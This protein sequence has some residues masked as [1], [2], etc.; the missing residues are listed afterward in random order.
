MMM[1]MMMIECDG[2][3]PNLI[4]IIIIPYRSDD[5]SPALSQ[6][7][8]IGQLVATRGGGAGL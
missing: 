5:D 3:F 7:G 8:D 2:D 4:I 6:L 1:M